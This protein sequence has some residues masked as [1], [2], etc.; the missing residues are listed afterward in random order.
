M[1]IPCLDSEVAI[2]MYVHLVMD[3]TVVHIVL[4]THLAVVAS[5]GALSGLWID[6]LCLQMDVMTLQ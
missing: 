4:L 5:G 6:T 2:N 1:C 3:G